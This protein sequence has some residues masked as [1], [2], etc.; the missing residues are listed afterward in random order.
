[1]NDEE[2]NRAVSRR[3]ALQVGSA[4][5]A[6][7]LAGCL[8]FFDDGQSADIPPLSE[9]RGSGSLVDGRPAPGG[10]SIEDLPNLSGDLALYIGGGESGIYYE[11]VEM[12]EDIYPDFEVH[13]T[14][15]SSSS[16]AQTIVEEADAGA[17]QADV[18]WSIDASSLGFVAEND[19]YEPLSD[20]AVEAVGNSQF[21]GDDNA[22]AGVAGRARAVPYNTNELSESDIPTTVQDFPDADAL[23]GTMGWAPTYGAFKA[24][25]TAMRLLRGDDET[26]NWLQSMSEAGTERRGNEYAVS[27]AVA[28]GSLSAGFANHYYAMRVKNNRP[29]APIDLA[30][31]EGDA[32]AL[33][34]VAGALKVQGTQKG[35]LVDNFV[36]HLL[37]AEAQE[38]FATISFAYPMISGVEPVG[39]LPTIDELSPPDIDLAELA[40]IEP[41]LELMDEA[42]VSG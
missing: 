40:D 18:F 2:G 31:T 20:E 14:D 17:A 21:V 23:Q 42:G 1:M 12:L 29:D 22:W 36:R 19:A 34:N 4:F 37:S 28:N 8:G 16:L 10:T 32:G 27:E 39:G 6:A 13:S 41:T 25:V 30:F 33:I 3:R 26:R 35:E 7:S 9:F 11:F 5:G 38:Y 24:F 15:N